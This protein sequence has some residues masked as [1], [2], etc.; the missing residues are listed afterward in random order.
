MHE[1]K[2][3]AA[4]AAAHDVLNGV[5][6]GKGVKQQSGLNL[7]L[8]HCCATLVGPRVPAAVSLVLHVIGPNIWACH[9]QSAAM[10]RATG[11]CLDLARSH[12]T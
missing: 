8:Y 9:V 3:T 4:A 10:Y 7:N 6:G 12:L 2:L 11:V 1:D 5:G